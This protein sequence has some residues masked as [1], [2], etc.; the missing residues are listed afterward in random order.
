MT[1]TL[2]SPELCPLNIYLSITNKCAYKNIAHDVTMVRSSEFA[3][4]A[5]GFYNPGFESHYNFYYLPLFK[6]LFTRNIPKL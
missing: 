4:K 6:P 5:C 2:D 3:G 1:F